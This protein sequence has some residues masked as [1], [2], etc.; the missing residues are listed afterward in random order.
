VRI[1]VVACSGG[2]ALLLMTSPALAGP[3]ADTPPLS[4]EEGA[5]IDIAPQPPSGKTTEEDVLA[6]GTEPAALATAP[7]AR[8]RS[9]G[10][11]L[12][13][14]LGVLG[15]AGQFRHVSPP[16]YWLHG[17][18][19]YE[20]FSWL[21][22]FG[23]GEI[24]LTDTSES[25]DETHT[26]AYSMWGVGGG[27][28]ATV[29]VSD[30][31]AIFGQ[32]DVGALTANVPHDALALLGYRAAESLDA[33]FGARLG[34]DYYQVDRHMA[35]CAALGAR[36]AQGFSKVSESSDVPLLW[37]LGAGVRYTF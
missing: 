3:P 4:E 17:Q 14:T 25:Q 33:A 12:E 26:L 36:V 13:S 15:F 34:V 11:V 30:R 19:G 8:P 27:A 29:H 37:D 16:A 1:A 28:R 9:K 18:L 10:L 21:M 24:A 23:E 32:G 31:V 7:P 5:R 35:L 22:L 20:V 6:G 2:I